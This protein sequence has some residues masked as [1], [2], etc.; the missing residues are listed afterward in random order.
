VALA[1]TVTI[2]DANLTTSSVDLDGAPFTSGTEVS[3]EGD[4]TLT[5][6]AEDAGG[7]ATTRIARFTLD[8]TLPVVSLSGVTEGTRFTSAPTP[9]F[10]AT[11][12]NLLLVS[13]TLNG[14]AFAS[15]TPIGADGAYTLVV[16]ARDRAGNVANVTVSFTVDLPPAPPAIARAEI[17]DGGIALSWTASTSADV[18]QYRVLRD[19]QALFL[20]DALAAAGGALPTGPATARF[21]VRAV[22]AF[23]Q[24]ST[25][26]YLTVN[27]VR[28]ALVAVGTPDGQGGS[29]L[30]RGTFDQLVLSVQNGDVLTHQAGPVALAL[31]DA[32]G[33]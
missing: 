31:D 29:K 12:A 6:T 9:I 30:T 15:G 27:P 32:D 19:G 18:T 25:P 1:P 33:I 2:E 7:R 16:T 26:R 28:V 14:G 22:D 17:S 4:H 3:A 13:A 23:G 21:E 20:G 5:A 8:F 11:D 24:L 10:S